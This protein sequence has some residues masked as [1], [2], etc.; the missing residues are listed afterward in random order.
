MRTTT[1][2]AQVTTVEDKIAGELNITQLIL[3]VTPVFVGAGVFVVLP[4]FFNYAIYKIVLIVCIAVLFAMLAIRIKE[5]II[6]QWLFILIRYTGRPR[7][8]L[9]NKNDTYMRD[10]PQPETPQATA[11]QAEPKKMESVVK[12]HLSIAELAQIERLLTN[13]HANLHFKTNK[14]GALSVHITEVQ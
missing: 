6:L 1:V 14:K 10:I 5:K 8:Y 2:P 3:L 12:P 9:F 11:K 7:Y 13:P 4:P